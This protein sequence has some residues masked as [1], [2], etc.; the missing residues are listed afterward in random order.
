MCDAAPDPSGRDGSALH[1][2]TTLALWSAACASG[3][4]AE[5]TWEVLAATGVRSGARAASDAAAAR[6]G[7]PG[8]GEAT[9]P[10][11]ELVPVLR[12]G[13]PAGLLLPVPG[14]VRGLPAGGDV[15]GPALAAGA[16][17]VLPAVGVALVPVGSQWQ[18]YECGPG[19]PALALPEARM[20]LDEAVRGATIAL[21]NAD[22]A[23][24]H[25]RP[26][27]AVSALVL[28]EQV[29]TPPGVPAAAADLLTR[30]I[31][32]HALLAVAAGHRT[33]AVTQHEL[34]TVDRALAPLQSAAR[35]ARRTA[36]ALAV[37]ALH[38]QP[39]ARQAARAAAT[40]RSAG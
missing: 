10:L 1:A 27:D 32:L 22:V 2:A 40:R 12:R 11:I 18:A 33:A 14:D 37:A 20:L 39:A 23:S 35:E 30:S 17:V 15:G 8:P 28:A 4:P 36:V 38:P 26:H 21:T 3:E 19:H 5:R 25:G 13:G 34:A 29:E 24:S 7:L 9:A 6:C 31:T 16:A